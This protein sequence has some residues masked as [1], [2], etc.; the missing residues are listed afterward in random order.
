MHC[1]CQRTKALYE[2]LTNAPGKVRSP[3]HTFPKTMTQKGKI[4]TSPDGS[5]CHPRKWTAC[6]VIVLESLTSKTLSTLPM[7]E[8]KSKY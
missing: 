8:W 7:K 4:P 6:Q 2:D 1:M 3:S 5:A